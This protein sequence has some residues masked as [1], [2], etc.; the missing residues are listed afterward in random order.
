MKA[1][2]DELNSLSTLLPC[3]CG[4]GKA[5]A[6][7]QQQDCGME[8]LQGLHG[9]YSGLQSQ[10][11]LMDPFPNATKI[12]A[13]VRQEEKQQE[14]HS[15]RPSITTPEAAALAVNSTVT[16]SA[17]NKYVPIQNRANFSSNNRAPHQN[18]PSKR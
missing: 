9:R 18:H 10:I 11:L 16:N 14:I 3:T 12:Y 13:L 5:Y 6:A 8:F 1:L 2:W 17:E 7:L 15:S 4:H